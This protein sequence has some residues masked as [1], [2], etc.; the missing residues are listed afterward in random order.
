MKAAKNMQFIGKEEDQP[1][2]GIKG[3]TENN[4]SQFHPGKTAQTHI[5]NTLSTGHLKTEEDND[6]S[7][8]R[9][10]T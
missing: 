10:E 1:D 9:K 3:H 2:F 8:D 7:Y 6:I 5:N 4:L